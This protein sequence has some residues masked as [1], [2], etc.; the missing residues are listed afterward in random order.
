MINKKVKEVILSKG[1]LL[2]RIAQSYPNFK[3]RR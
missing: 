3:I 2:R 1:V